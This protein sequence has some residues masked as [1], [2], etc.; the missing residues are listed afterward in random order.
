MQKVTALLPMKGHSERVPGKNLKSFGGKPLF[1]AILETMLQSPHIDEV[2]INT[3]SE[4]IAE[5]ATRH[6]SRVRIIWRPE[7]IQGDTVSMN[8]IIEYDLNQSENQHFLQTHSTNPLLT[9]KTLNRAIETYFA[10]L[11]SHDSL[12]GVT[13]WQTRFYWADGRPVNHNP[14]ELLRTQDLP[15]VYEENSNFYL[16]SKSAFLANDKKRIGLKP[17]LFEVDKLEALDIDEPPD[18]ELAEILYLKNNR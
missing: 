4:Q 18:F 14:T 2:L 9:V 15:I 11:Q 12:F 8:K 10:H 17:Y 6:S 16:F 13:R 7:E 5:V 1:L 3:D